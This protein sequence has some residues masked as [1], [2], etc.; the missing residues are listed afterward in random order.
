MALL[1]KLIMNM[2]NKKYKKFGFTLI[3]V[4]VSLLLSAMVA[5]FVYT[6]LL[7]SYS[8][9]NRLSF[10][11]KNTSSIKFFTTVFNNSV[12]YANATPTV[13]YGTSGTVQALT[14]NRYDKNYKRMVNEKYYFSDGGEFILDQNLSVSTVTTHFCKTLGLLKKDIIFDGKVQETIVVSNIIR[15][16]YYYYPTSAPTNF[17]RYRRMDVCVVY[18]DVVNAKV[19]KTTGKIEEK[20]GN[21]TQMGDNNSTINRRLFTYAFRGFNA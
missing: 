10:S 9:Y 4:M 20:E 8:G 12:K 17:K 19:N 2:K 7:S 3:E 21:M 1:K 15:T 14:F 6:M 5:F 11:S 16:I 18:D 13:E